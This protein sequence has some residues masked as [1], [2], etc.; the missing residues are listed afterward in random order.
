[1]LR[2]GVK[3]FIQ[4]GTIADLEK[5]INEFLAGSI[6]GDICDVSVTNRNIAD[7]LVVVVKY[8][9]TVQEEKAQVMDFRNPLLHL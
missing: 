8:L 1:M 4:N 5:E 6:P 7:E 2:T 3:I 9:Y